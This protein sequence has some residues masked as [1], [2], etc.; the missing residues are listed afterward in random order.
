MQHFKSLE[1]VHLQNS[2][3]T[4]GS[5]DGVHLGH[6]EIIRQLVGEAHHKGIYAVALTFFPHPAIVLGKRQDTQ[7][8]TTPV[9]RADIMGSMGVDIVITYPFSQNTANMTARDFVSLLHEHI[10]FEGLCVGHDFALGKN[11]EGDSETLTKLGDEYGYH[12]RFVD[13]VKNGEMIVSSS[14]IRFGILEGEVEQAAQLLGR[15]YRISGRVIKGDG[16]GK[17]IG[18]PTANLETWPEQAIP[19][20]GVYATKVR[21]RK[22]SYQAVVNVGVRPT[23]ELGPVIPRVEA[24]ILNFH[25][26]IYGDE[27]ELNFVA[28]LRDER[29]FENIEALIAQIRADISRA[30][31]ILV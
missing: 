17:S 25:E 1:G 8:L 28:R 31:Q 7:Y 22:Q 16:R 2:W 4:I 13:P 11:R 15:Y 12:V 19:K 9:E 21:H 5:F 23:F 29:R 10:K 26:E 30:K 18:I 3:L 14:R 20:A 24:H 27:I 6:Q